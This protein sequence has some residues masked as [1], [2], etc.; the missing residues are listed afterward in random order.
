[1][2]GGRRWWWTYSV[3]SEPSAPGFSSV[4]IPPPCLHL[5]ATK[6][7]DHR[8]RGAFIKHQLPRTVKTVDSKGTPGDRGL[9]VCSSQRRHPLLP[10]RFQT[11]LLVEAVVAA[12]MTSHSED[13]DFK[14]ETRRGG[15]ELL[16]KHPVACE[17]VQCWRTGRRSSENTPCGAEV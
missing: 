15:D 16:H 3:C 10:L 1:M 7:G 14:R 2:G 17:H 4:D 13:H 11:G 9:L 5:K 6:L 12:E 8:G